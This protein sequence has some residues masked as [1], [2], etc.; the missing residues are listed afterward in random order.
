M[1]LLPILGRELRVR[2]RGQANYWTRFCVALAGVL[3]CIQ[4]LESS[5]W[6]KA[7]QLGAFVFNG[8]VGA[9]FLVSCTTCLLTAD[10]ISSEWRE[11]TLS[12]LFLTRVRVLDVLL[13]KLASVGIAGL[14]AL[15]AFLPV[16]MVP[17]LAGGVTG[18]EAYRKC[19][20]LLDLLFLSLVI[21]LFSSAAERERS[22][23]LRRTL[24]LVSLVV[25]VPFLGYVGWG[26]GLFFYAGLFSPLVLLIRAGDQAY[27]TSPA[28]FWLAFALVLCLGWFFLV[29]AGVRLHRAVARDGGLSVGQQRR[30]AE[31]LKRAVGLGVW[32][33]AKEESSPVEWLVYRQY[34]VHAAIWSV[35][36]LALACNAWVPLVRQAQGM[37]SGPFFL[38]VA[39]PL[40]TVSGLIG[41]AVVAW[42][43]SRFFVGVRRTG[44]LELLLT[45]PVGAQSIIEDQWRVLKRLFA[46]PVLCMQ[47]PMLPQFLSGLSRLRGPAATGL[48]ADLPLLNILTVANAFLGAAALCWLGLLFGLR[49][50]TQASA[51]VWTVGLG[52]GIPSL[53][54]LIS[55]LAAAASTNP[56]SGATAGSAAAWWIPEIGIALF[57]CW[58]IV[59]ARRCL[60]SDLAGR[61]T[62]LPLSPAGE[63]V[64]L[65]WT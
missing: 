12:L 1:T 8:I 51:I 2:A 35:G 3:L 42:V 13:G 27:T 33:P 34:G 21:G 54:G 45:T 20:G 60:A 32:Q 52:K 50:R 57:Y 65:S 46:W 58:L 56:W 37:P 49:S 59:T 31:E 22:R 16:L 6:A 53:V 48:G 43:A 36:V 14:C 24:L 41:G 7:S 5:T 26:R 40:G 39:S 23:A 29:Q 62:K 15:L 4:S 44:D 30:A 28:L 11:G 25:V 17:V 19:L 61:E 55:S 9:A 18:G 10:A 63:T 47:A 38:A 64:Q